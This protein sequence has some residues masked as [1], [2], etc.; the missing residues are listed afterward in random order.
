MTHSLTSLLERL[1]TLKIKLEHSSVKRALILFRLQCSKSFYC[2]ERIDKATETN[3]TDCVALAQWKECYISHILLC[4]H[5]HRLCW[6]MKRM[7]FFTH[8]LCSH[9]TSMRLYFAQS[10][11][12]TLH[13]WV[14][15]FINIH[16]KAFECKHKM[17][18]FVFTCL[19]LAPSSNKGLSQQKQIFRTL[20]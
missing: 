3:N 11:I 6:T 12:F 9:C 20:S 17:F 18:V 14:C 16:K 13:G 2:K 7:L 10:K 8:F 1:V 19:A 5:F 4:S 15:V